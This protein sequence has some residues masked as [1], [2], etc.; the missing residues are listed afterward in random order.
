MNSANE[1]LQFNQYF[2]AWASKVRRKLRSNARWF[3]DGK[4]EGFVTR[5]IHS[6]NLRQEG[7]LADSIYTRMKQDYGRYDSVSFNFERHGVFIHKGVGR[8]YKQTG[9]FV[10]RI[11]KYDAQKT[12]YAVEWFN[13]VLNDYLPELADKVAESDANAAMNAFRGNIK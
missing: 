10:T 13:P 6:G 4:T 12:R 1:N 5:G 9:S 7:K 3:S 2:R 11:A 8:G